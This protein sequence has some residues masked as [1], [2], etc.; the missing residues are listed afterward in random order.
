M[1]GSEGDGD[2]VFVVRGGVNGGLEF[3]LRD[4]YGFLVEL[5]D[6]LNRIETIFRCAVTGDG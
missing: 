6:A 5:A 2:G 3:G 1:G 4:A